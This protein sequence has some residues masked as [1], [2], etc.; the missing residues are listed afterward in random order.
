MAKY[1]FVLSRGLGDPVRATR[2]FQFAKVAKEKGHEVNIFLVDDGA[3]YAVPGMAGNVKAPTGDDAKAYLDFLQQNNVPFYVCT[4]CAQIRQL[5]DSN[6]ID[7]AQLATAA[8][9]I[10]LAEDSKV[11]TF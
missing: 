10:D 3:F 5:D 7:G 8:Q 11:F 6:M 2:T 9:L 1:L 4:P